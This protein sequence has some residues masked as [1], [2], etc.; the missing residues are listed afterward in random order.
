MVSHSSQN[1]HIVATSL[2]YCSCEN[3]TTSTL[4]FRH[5]CAGGRG[6]HEVNY[7]QWI[8]DCLPAIFGLESEG[9]A[10]QDIGSVDLREGRLLT[11]PNILRH[12]LEPF[13]LADPTKSGHRKI[14]ALF[15][16]DPNIKVI[17][18]ANVL[19]QHQA[20]GWRE[21]VRSC[22]SKPSSMPD[23]RDSWLSRLPAEL[24][25]QILASVC[26][27]GASQ[28][29]THRGKEMVSEKGKRSFRERE[30]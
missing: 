23:M 17:N 26:K 18:T 30:V 9:P 13:K 14:T 29:G 7:E 21:V 6:Y 4:S 19:C 2:Y 10:V 11:Y 27:R 22:C 8:H 12:R 3:V 25:D 15:L 16:V 20:W 1:E 5:Q 24:Q 28:I